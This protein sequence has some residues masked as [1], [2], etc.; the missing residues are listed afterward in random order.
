MC[1]PEEKKGCKWQGE[2]KTNI[3]TFYYP[4]KLAALTDPDAATS[5]LAM[6]DFELDVKGWWNAKV[7]RM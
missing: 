6:K 5:Q 7:S 4:H 3:R 2:H 1:R